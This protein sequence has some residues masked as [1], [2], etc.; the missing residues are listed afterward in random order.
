MGKQQNTGISTESAGK[1]DLAFEA[2]VE[3]QGLESLLWLT[4]AGM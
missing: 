3:S 4:L 2:E 1:S